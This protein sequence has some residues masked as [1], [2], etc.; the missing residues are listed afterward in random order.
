MI[1]CKIKK[2]SEL[3]NNE[4][5][6]ILRVRNQVFIVEQECA[7]QDIDEYDQE[8]YHFFIN[9]NEHIIAYLRVLPKGMTFNEVSIGRIL[10]TE[11]NRKR[12]LAKLI[13]E[14]AIKFIT[15]ELN[16]DVIEISAQT[17]LIKFY[18]SLGF[19][20]ISEVYLE[21]GLEHIDML[22]QK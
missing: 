13:L 1:E 10:V 2:F 4:L 22:Y 16:E 7:F 20:I 14:I 8:A 3:T 11:H 19:K 9:D 21:D 12:G 5:Y 6:E 17:Y 15:D 18:E